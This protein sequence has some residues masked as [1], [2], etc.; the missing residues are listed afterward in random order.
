MKAL[1]RGGY[2]M[3]LLQSG[4]V[5]I[6]GGTDSSA[7]VL[8]SAEIFDPATGAFS[9]TA[10]AMST[11]RAKASATTLANGQV[12]LAGGVG[13]GT[14]STASAELYDPASSGFTL[15]TSTMSVA[16]AAQQATLLKD[17]TV[18]L[19]GGFDSQG[20]S[21]AISDFF[22]PQ[23]SSLQPGPAMIMARTG[24]TATL[25]QNGDVL[26]AGGENQGTP[27]A[28]AELYVPDS[29]GGSF[30]PLTAQMTTSRTGA[31]A[32]LLPDG[33]VLI[34]GGVGQ[35]TGTT[36]SNLA[37]G[38][39]YD[40][41]TRQFSAAAN[42]MSS[43]R[44]LA[45]SALLSDGTILVAG[46]YAGTPQAFFT[47]PT[48][49]VDIFD[50]STDR[51]APAAASQ[52]A[53]AAADAVTLTDGR[54]FIPG[55]SANDGGILADAELY[56][57]TPTTSS[58]DVSGGMHNLR[59]FHASTRLPDGRILICGGTNFYGPLASAETFDPVAGLFTPTSPMTEPRSVGTATLLNNGQVLV[60]GG[61][62]DTKA[63]LFDPA[64]NTFSPIASRMNAV[65]S[66]HT[67]TLLKDGTVLLAG[68]IV[69]I[70]DPLQTAELFDFASNTF[71]A[72]GDMTQ[73]R[74]GA[75]ATLLPDGTVLIVGGSTTGAIDGGG[76]T[77]SA[78]L[79]DPA[80]RSFTA[81]SATLDQ[82]RFRA[83]AAL[84][85]DG[86]VLIVDGVNGLSNDNATLGLA[87]AQVYL[88]ATREFTAPSGQPSER[89]AYLN[90]TLLNDGRVLLTGGGSN[91][92]VSEFYDPT[93]GA[94]QL[95]P[96]MS[97]GRA[98]ATAN[99][100]A[101]SGQVLI[102][103]GIGGSVGGAD[104]VQATTE[105]WTP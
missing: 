59:E 27:L 13:S 58:S 21:L 4:Q 18:L 56:T 103:G 47:L 90:A 1:G 61:S 43:T 34:S 19:T 66:F 16:R 65:R 48:A 23:T 44:F 91:D 32:R 87:D 22:D 81:L 74:D 80:T 12:L 77:N 95:G 24:H 41:A 10:G 40:P 30:V 52:I 100:L 7:K 88:P 45:A 49:A 72:V 42:L 85:N 69:K 78:E 15:L 84:L 93:S 101:Q 36:L 33:R 62:G 55:G 37:S 86:T 60:A 64:T 97:Y 26:I 14:L 2:A 67:S 25:L 76:A 96:S 8:A 98:D 38:D 51:F 11:P 46:G 82:P 63:E 70:G 54:V 79:Y 73:P 89:R 68:G 92:L 57:V 39:L 17:G 104:Y 83:A 53:R 9:L 35:S 50:P 6:A 29:G 31:T 28:E 105:V 20:D 102:A 5:L 75:T 3:A 71:T 99:L 94:F